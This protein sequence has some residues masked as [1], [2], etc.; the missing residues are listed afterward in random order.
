LRGYA[1]PL[2]Q[3]SYNLNLG[4]RRVDSVRNALK[5]WDGG[6]LVQYIN[7]G[8]LVIT[9]RSFGE[10]S[11]PTGISD[12]ESEALKSIYSPNASRERRVEI[13]EINFKN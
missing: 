9:E 8:Q 13:D 10:T 4:K 12:K 6:I 3:D 2:A 1:S 7:S 5:K 11:A